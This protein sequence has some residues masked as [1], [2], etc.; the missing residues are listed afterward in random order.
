MLVPHPSTKEE[1]PNLTGNVTAS[2]FMFYDNNIND[3]YIVFVFS[4]L[5]VRTPGNYKLVF[6]LYPVIE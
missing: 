2:P 5:Y 1:T 3:K 4:K 6:S